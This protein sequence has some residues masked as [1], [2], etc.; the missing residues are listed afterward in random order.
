MSKGFGDEDPN[1]DLLGGFSQHMGFRKGM[2]IASLNVNSL[3]CHFDEIQL[4][5]K[6]YGSI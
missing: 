3:R 1:N 6:S 4:L 5:L 2:L